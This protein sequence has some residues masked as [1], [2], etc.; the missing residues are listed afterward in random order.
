MRNVWIADGLQ[1]HRS[2]NCARVRRE[3]F[4]SLADSCAPS[5]PPLYILLFLFLST[6]T[7]TYTRWESCS[8]SRGNKRSA[9]RGYVGLLRVKPPALNTA[10]SRENSRA[11]ARSKIHFWNIVAPSALLNRF[12]IQSY[13]FILYIVIIIRCGCACPVV[14]ENIFYSIVN[15]S[16]YLCII[17][18][19]YL[20]GL[21]DAYAARF[22]YHL[23]R[24]REISRNFKSVVNLFAFISR[25]FRKLESR[26]SISLR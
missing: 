5:T 3:I 20:C 4:D 12:A 19:E 9:F 11:R 21:S 14:G 23:A 13:I 6:Y 15:R 22:F 7:Y 8:W 18:S 16:E 26:A 2:G 25:L 24:S 17:M 1:M 10:N